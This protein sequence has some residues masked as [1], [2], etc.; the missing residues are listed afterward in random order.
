M[1]KKWLTSWMDG[2]FSSAGI[3]STSVAVL[4]VPEDCRKK[5]VISANKWL[6]QSYVEKGK[7]K[8]EKVKHH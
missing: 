7:K 8:I 2:T 6:I 3:L 1:D 5:T 4:G